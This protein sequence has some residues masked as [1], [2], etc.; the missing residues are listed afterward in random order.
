MIFFN[1][2]RKLKEL[3]RA[4]ELIATNQASF[5]KTFIG[6]VKYVDA[7]QMRK[8]AGMTFKAEEFFAKP[9]YG[10][11]WSEEEKKLNKNRKK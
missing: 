10:T 2:R 3:E 8:Y 11:D 5:S 4:V 6:S 7:A 1:T 9:D